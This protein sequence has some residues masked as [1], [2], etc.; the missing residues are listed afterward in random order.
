MTLAL[1]SVSRS[2]GGVRA[3]EDATFTVEKGEVH[4]LI[5]PNGAG[6]TTL[7]NLISGL[8]QPTQGEIALEGQRIDRLPAH[9][10]AARGVARTYQNI[11]LFAGLSAAGNV[12]VGEHLRRRAPLWPRLLLLPSARRE[13]RAAAQTALEALARVL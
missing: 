9:R 10:I 3:V 7:V 8:L 5:G 1:Q 2:F 6:K 4:G 11:R 13:E 12:V